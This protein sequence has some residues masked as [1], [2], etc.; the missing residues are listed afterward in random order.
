MLR[1][2]A[3]YLLAAAFLAAQ[4]AG[5]AHQAWHDASPVVAHADEAAGEGKTPQKNLL[6]DFHTALS[7]VLG[8]VDGGSHAVAPHVQ[9]AIAFARADAAAPGHSTLTPRSRAPPT[10]L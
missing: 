8:A 10:L 6:C 2:L 7:A 1:R 4:G 5:V 3:R 9:S